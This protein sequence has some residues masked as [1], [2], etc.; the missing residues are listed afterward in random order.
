LLEQRPLRFD[1]RKV[2]F[3]LTFFLALFQQAM[4]APHTF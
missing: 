1:V 4:L 3:A 2:L